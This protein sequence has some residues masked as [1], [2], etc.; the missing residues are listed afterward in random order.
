MACQHSLDDQ[1]LWVQTGAREDSFIYLLS[2][3]ECVVCE[4]QET[5]E[6]SQCVY[7]ACV[8]SY[9]SAKPS[10]FPRIP[11]VDTNII[12]NPWIPFVDDDII[13]LLFTTPKVCKFPH[14]DYKVIIHPCSPDQRFVCL[15]SQ[16]TIHV[17]VLLVLLSLRT[18][19]VS[20]HRHGCS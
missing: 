9:L 15:N 13:H 5:E 7:Y 1:T 8:C 10:V 3:P 11:P 12:I 2:S 16:R 14:V 17:C 20:R 4:R 6:E 18:M 19:P